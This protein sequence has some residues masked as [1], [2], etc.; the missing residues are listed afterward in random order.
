MDIY[1]NIIEKARPYHY[2]AVIRCTLEA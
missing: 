2:T 1:S